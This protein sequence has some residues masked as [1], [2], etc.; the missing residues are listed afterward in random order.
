VSRSLTLRRFRSSNSRTS[1]M[2]TWEK[3]LVTSTTS[4][5]VSCLQMTIFRH[6][7]PCIAHLQPIRSLRRKAVD[8]QSIKKSPEGPNIKRTSTRP[9]LLFHSHVQASKRMNGELSKLIGKTET[10]L[11]LERGDVGYAWLSALLSEHFITFLIVISKV[12]FN[13]V[14]RHRSALRREYHYSRRSAFGTNREGHE[15]TRAGV[16]ILQ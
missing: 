6:L 11:G 5:G 2:S 12:A 4:P 16:N 8:H 7:L 3:L 9:E 13:F 15:F 1:C 10:Y 14:E